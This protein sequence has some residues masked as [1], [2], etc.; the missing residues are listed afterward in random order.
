[1]NT[2]NTHE[3]LKEIS[4]KKKNINKQIC[5]IDEIISNDRQLKQ[6]FI[7]RNERLSSS[8]RIFSLSNFVEILQAEKS[9][10]ILSILSLKYS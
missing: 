6:E 10:L 2:N 3:Y 4:E 1:M 9:G 7:R 8:E 5:T